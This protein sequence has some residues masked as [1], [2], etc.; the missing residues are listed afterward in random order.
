MFVPCHGLRQVW[1]TWGT[2]GCL[3]LLKTVHGQVPQEQANSLP[4]RRCLLS[5]STKPG[6]LAHRLAA[7]LGSLDIRA[8]SGS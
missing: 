4:A 1:V 3:V 8:P 2:A 7:S 5:G 6:A